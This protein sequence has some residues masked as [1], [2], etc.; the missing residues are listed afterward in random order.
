[1]LPGPVWTALL[2][3]TSTWSHS[4]M[5]RSTAAVSDARSMRSIGTDSARRPRASIAAAVVSRLPGMTPPPRSES[6]TPSPSWTVR[7]VMATSKPASA[8]AIAVAF[9]MPRLAPVTRAVRSLM[10]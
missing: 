9:P 3:S 1:M 5:T 2:T 7:A 10:G 4:A 6:S 8:S